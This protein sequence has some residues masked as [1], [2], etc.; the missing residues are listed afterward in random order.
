V[1]WTKRNASTNRRVTFS[2][3]RPPIEIARAIAIVAHKQ[4][5]A[6]QMPNFSS[7]G[8]KKF[9]IKLLRQ[10]HLSKQGGI[11]ARVVSFIEKFINV[12]AI[13]NQDY[14]FLENFCCLS[15]VRK[16]P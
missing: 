16:T 5:N 1:I 7:L 9:L 14:H 3:E 10:H 11:A 6:G 15:T 8:V 12:K 2:D 13:L 4:Y